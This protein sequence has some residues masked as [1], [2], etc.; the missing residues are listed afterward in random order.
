M[1]Q[2]SPLPTP[3]H[4]PISVAALSPS[5]RGVPFLFGIPSHARIAAPPGF[6][7]CPPTAVG[8]FLGPSP[9]TSAACGPLSCVRPPPT[10]HNHPVCVAGWCI[11]TPV[12]T[13]LSRCCCL[14]S[15]VSGGT[16]PSPGLCPPP[17]GQRVRPWT[18][19]VVHPGVLEDDTLPVAC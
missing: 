18:T 14:G 2:L 5:V 13:P 16:P 17:P 11:L 12:L 7:S 9:T 10:E 8:V 6:P 3:T 1:I 19:R 4:L 15:V